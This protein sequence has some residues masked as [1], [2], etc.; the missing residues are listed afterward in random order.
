MN[1]RDKLS[2]IKIEDINIIKLLVNFTCFIE[3]TSE[4]IKI[5]SKRVEYRMVNSKSDMHKSLSINGFIPLEVNALKYDQN[6][7]PNALKKS[8]KATLAT[9]IKS[10]FGMF[11]SVGAISLNVA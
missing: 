1:K 5:I 11:I 3:N 8:H 7:F 10:S 2:I 4:K 6:I 9:N